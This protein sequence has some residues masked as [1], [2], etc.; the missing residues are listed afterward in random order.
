MRAPGFWWAEK[1]GPLARLLAPIGHV[2]GAVTA[3]RMG[4][5]G[6]RASLPVI[7]IGNLTAG[8]AGKTP[9]TIALAALLRTGGEAPVILSRGYGG[10]LTGPVLVDPGRHDASAVGDEPLLLARHAPVVV[11]RDRIAGAGLAA[12]HGNV[13]LMDDGL[14][15]PSLV[16]DA[17]FAVIDAATGIG[18]GLAIPAGPLRAPLPAQLPHVHALITVG[19]GAAHH[20]VVAAAGSR[21]VFAGDLV[22]DQSTAAALAGRR[23]LAFAGI[24]RPEKFFATLREIGAEVVDAVG[25]GDH[26]P[27]R[28]ADLAALATRAEGRGAIPVTTEKDA[29]RLGPLTERV[30]G[31]VILPVSFVPPDGAALAAFLAQRIAA[32]RQTL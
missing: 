30:P 16:K 10:G 12:R 23:V 27:Y 4:R 24:G 8:G 29:A 17:A 32:A 28:E 5:S 21:P 22:P 6:I 13:L 7:C 11:A 9:V 26:Q 18:N 20:R 31:L 25:F 3:A 2:Y 15:N 14:Q 1:P 19:R